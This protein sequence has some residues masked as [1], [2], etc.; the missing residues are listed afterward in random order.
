M[1]APTAPMSARPAALALIAAMTLPMSL[2]D[3][4]PVALDR[5]ADQGIEFGVGEW[6]RQVGAQQPQ[7]RLFLGH[8][9]GT[10][11]GGKLA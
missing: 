5:F 7:F 10:A 9:V 4:A 6:R 3:A 1:R 8:Q 2:I 11:A